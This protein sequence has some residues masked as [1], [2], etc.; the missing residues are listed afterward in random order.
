MSWIS[1]PRERPHRNC[2]PQHAKDNVLIAA[3]NEN[4]IVVLDAPLACAHLQVGLI[5]RTFAWLCTFPEEV[6]C[7]IVA[8]WSGRRSSLC[9]AA[10]VINQVCSVEGSGRSQGPAVSLGVFMCLVVNTGEILNKDD[11]VV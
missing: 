6:F 9:E 7:L 8:S 1:A 3:S 5:H 11:L 4:F 2:A 10:S